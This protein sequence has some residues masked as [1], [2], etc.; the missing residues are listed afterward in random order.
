MNTPRQSCPGRGADRPKILLLA[1]ITFWAT[2]LAPVAAQGL[3]RVQLTPTG[4][5]G[6]ADEMGRSV[7][8]VG[9]TAFVGAPNTWLAPAYDAGVVDIYR[10]HN[11]V[12][13]NEG[14]L[15]A[16]DALPE[17]RFGGAIAG[18]DDLLVAT[19]GTGIYTFERDGTSWSQVDKLSAPSSGD[20]GLSGDTL[21]SAGY[22]YVRAGSGWQLQTQIIPDDFG[23]VIENSAVDGNLLAVTSYTRPTFV[24]LAQHVYFYSRSG[25]TWNRE[26]R[27]ELS[28]VKPAGI[29]S[30]SHVA[31]SGDTAIVSASTFDES[32]VR[33]YTRDGAGTWSDRGILDAGTALH[34]EIHVDLEGDRAVVTGGDGTAYTFVRSDDTWTREL[35]F[36]DPSY[37]NCFASVSLSGST[38]LAGCP[39]A[40]MP[41]GA[42]GKA[43]VFSLDSNPPPITAQFDQGNAYQGAHFGSGVALS[44]STMAVASQ[45][46]AYVFEHIGENWTQQA[47][48]FPGYVLATPALDGDTVALMTTV[49]GPGLVKILTRT[50]S[51]WTEQQTLSES[52][53]DFGLALALQGNVLAV[54]EPNSGGNGNPPEVGSCHVF[55]RVGT[56]WSENAELQPAEG[57]S[58]DQFCVSV[59]LSNDTLLVGAPGS[60]IDIEYDAGAAYVFVRSQGTW[61]QQARLL[62]PVPAVGAA[63][64]RS[65]AIKGDTAVIGAGWDGG[66]RG[67]AYVYKRNGDVW[68]WQATLAPPLTPPFP[69]SFGTSVAISDSEDKV[70]VSM[71]W[72]DGPY[73]GLVFAFELDAGQWSYASTLR[74]TLGYPYDQFG[75]SVSMSGQDFA[76]GAPSDGVG[77]AVYQGSLSRSIFFSG[78]E[79]SP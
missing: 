37:I 22:V 8:L 46:G 11:G 69:S 59:S 50:N 60:N 70:L 74:A 56:T 41:S 65:V 71:P 5:G 3:T 72:S 51:T 58:N 73:V 75:D 25:D 17:M 42:F 62:A 32:S 47:Q 66:D 21:A 63:L 13:Q 53:P 2:I 20:V 49:S 33:V 34:S 14:F 24:V 19:A 67:A 44:G 28:Q 52:G 4:I 45:S 27:I 16:S 6:P 61:S 54:G 30:P 35:H 48:L 29:L 26:A 7:S 39:G 64:G 43:D 68:S 10:Q 78:F 23:E 15:Y 57:E 1:G 76:I 55:E 36:N 38:L 31:I 9:D 18:G 79:S 40:I 77:G 12:W